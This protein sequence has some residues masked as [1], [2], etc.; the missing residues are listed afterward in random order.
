M[1]SIRSAAGGALAAQLAVT[2]ASAAE[3]QILGQRLLVKATPRVVVVVGK[4]T[5]TDIPSIV[6]DPTANGATLRIITDGDTSSDETYA[7]PAADWSARRAGFKFTGV[8]GSVVSASVVLK[9]TPAGLASL[10]AVIS[11]GIVLPPDAGTAGG[12]ILAIN[13]GD[14]YCVSFGGEAGGRIRIN[15]GAV[16]RVV[17]PTDEPGCLVAAPRCCSLPGAPSC[18]WTRS[19]TACV[20]ASNVPG[21]PGT[22]CDSLT[23]GCVAPPASPGDC[24]GGL[25]PDLDGACEAGP[26]LAQEPALCTAAGGTV[27]PNAVCLPSG[28]CSPSGAFLDGPRWLGRHGEVPARVLPRMDR[29]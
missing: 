10:R 24:C 9:R 15:T 23:G 4:E 2:L 18:G 22:V 17:K 13:G 16:W 26:L 8:T 14:T 7:L 21:A 25:T 20:F 3:Q 27:V 11:G 1:V 29:R 12:V 28:A 5:A 6:G 19:A